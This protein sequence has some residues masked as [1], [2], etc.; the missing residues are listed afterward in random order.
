MGESSNRCESREVGQSKVLDR[1]R[2]KFEA[3]FC[4]G[5]QVKRCLGYRCRSTGGSRLSSH[6][7]GLTSSSASL[8]LSL[9]FFISVARLSFQRYGLRRHGAGAR[10]HSGSPICQAHECEPSYRC[11][12]SGRQGAYRDDGLLEKVSICKVQNVSTFKRS[13]PLRPV[14][15]HQLLEAHRQ[16]RQSPAL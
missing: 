11:T 12:G 14:I 13:L 6:M 10:T 4:N 15:G 16:R 7:C 1:V 8:S 2:S 9:F 5:G 3:S